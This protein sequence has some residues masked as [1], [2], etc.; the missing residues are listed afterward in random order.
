MAASVR[1][2]IDLADAQPR[3]RGAA[4]VGKR[5]N[6]ATEAKDILDAAPLATMR[7]RFEGNFE[8]RT[9]RFRIELRS[10]ARQKGGV[11][12][13]LS[14]ALLGMLVG[15]SRGGVRKLSLS[16]FM[17]PFSSSSVHP[18]TNTGLGSH[19]GGVG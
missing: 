13:R 7:Q 1:L 2:S 4:N 11:V 3:R 8:K 15:A 14:K 6:V 12:A 19:C 17:L 18:P 5:F 10:A 16:K 9:W